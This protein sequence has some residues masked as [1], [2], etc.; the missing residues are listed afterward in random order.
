MRS[1]AVIAALALGLVL[2]PA[3][4]PLSAGPEKVAFPSGDQ[5]SVLYADVDRPDIKQ[6]RRLFAAPE[7]A[8]GARAGAPLPVG[9]LLTMEIYA[10]RT[11]D[12]G[13]PLRDGNGRL[14]RRALTAVFVMEE[15]R[16]VG[17]GV[18]G[19]S[20][21]RRVGIRAVHRR[22]PFRPR[23]HPGVSHV[24]QAQGGPGLRVLVREADRR[25]I[26]GAAARRHGPGAI[27]GP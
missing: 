27:L 26:A 21:Q 10:A 20:A 6:V 24:P 25:E 5:R 11:D 17:C 15:A 3:A 23:R 14:V 13:E 16:R 19:R 8:R 22:R 2:L 18:S 12:R 1:P 7:T 9:A 4:P